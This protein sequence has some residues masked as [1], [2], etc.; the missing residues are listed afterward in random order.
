MLRAASIGFVKVA[1]GMW[2]WARTVDARCTE[3]EQ[4]EAREGKRNR[5]HTVQVC[6]MFANGQEARERD[7]EGGGGSAAGREAQ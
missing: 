6:T 4:R 1:A 5:V 7:G 3:S 2:I